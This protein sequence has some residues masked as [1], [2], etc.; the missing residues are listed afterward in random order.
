MKCVS[1]NNC[2][3]RK[4]FRNYHTM[5]SLYNIWSSLDCI[6]DR[7]Q[8]LSCLSFFMFSGSPCKSGKSYFARWLDKEKL[9]INL[10][11]RL[12]PPFTSSFFEIFFQI[13]VIF[14]SEDPC[15]FLPV[16]PV[17]SFL[18]PPVYLVDIKSLTIDQ[19]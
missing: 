16:S 1:R 17:F 7:R 4:L 19:S 3:I 8:S 2:T 15:I 18:S 5:Q 14:L 13:P 11:I 10:K 12:P 6:K 9:F